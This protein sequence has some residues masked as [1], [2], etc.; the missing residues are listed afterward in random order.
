MLWLWAFGYILQEMTGNDKIIPIYIYGGVLG[1]IFF[2][3]AGNLIPPIHNQVNSTAL[4]G[5]NASTM[6]VAMATTTLSPNH[7]F[8]TQIRGGIPIWVLMALYLIIDLVG[9]SSYNAAYSFSHIGGALAGFLFV[10]L[11]RQGK[12]GSIWMNN[13]YSWFINLFNPNKKSSGNTV[14][15]KSVL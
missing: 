3:L 14:K 5:A 12:D 10:V 15:N 13:L 1:A 8:F 2:V 6:A 9:V 11:M 7:K 4:L